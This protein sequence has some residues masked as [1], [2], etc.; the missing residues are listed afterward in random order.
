M[1]GEIKRHDTPLLDE[2]KKGPW[3]SF[4]KEIDKAAQRNEMANGLLGQ[5][6]TS[7][8]EKISH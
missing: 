4:V 5:L 2:L 3:P 7:Y 8:R 6:E 1:G